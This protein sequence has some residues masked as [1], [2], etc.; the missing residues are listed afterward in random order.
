MLSSRYRYIIK[1]PIKYWIFFLNSKDPEP[2]PLFNLTDPDIGGQLFTDPLEPDPDPHTAL[3]TVHMATVL[4]VCLHSSGRA[5]N[6]G[7]ERDHEK[8]SGRC[9]LEDTVH[10][11]VGEW[12]KCL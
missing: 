5:G 10:H 4:T 8:R 12:T 2:D 9:S 11:T 6:G 3:E 1:Y 7:V